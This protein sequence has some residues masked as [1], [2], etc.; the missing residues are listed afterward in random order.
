VL[1][2]SQQCHHDH[3]QNHGDSLRLLAHHLEP[4]CF[5]LDTFRVR[6]SPEVTA[7]RVVLDVLTER[8]CQAGYLLVSSPA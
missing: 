5:R 6:L 8:I 4:F 1:G 3:D 2:D 7:R